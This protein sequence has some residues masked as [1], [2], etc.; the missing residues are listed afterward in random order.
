MKEV[1][2][3]QGE[4]HIK[5]ELLADSSG[6]IEMSLGLEKLYVSSLVDS[7][8]MQSCLMRRTVNPSLPSPSLNNN[9]AND[10]ACTKKFNW[11]LNI[12]MDLWEASGDAFIASGE[13]L[14]NDGEKIST[15]EE[16]YAS[17]A[18]AGRVDTDNVECARE[19]DIYEDGEIRKSLVQPIE[20]D[21]MAE[22]MDSGKNNESSSKN[23]HYSLCFTDEEKGYSMPLHTHESHD[24]FMKACDDKVEKILYN[25][26]VFRPGTCSSLATFKKWKK[27]VFIYGGG[28]IPFTKE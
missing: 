18:F 27:E 1:V 12:P 20:E 21:P 3:K 14:T 6:H 13:G 19:D 16:C 17:D 15:E 23:V 4:S 24:D 25:F 11:D 2:S 22:G 8:T 5:L 26:F 10:T 9:D 7:N 28:E